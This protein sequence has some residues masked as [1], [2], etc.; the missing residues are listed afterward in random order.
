MV[1][2]SVAPTQPL[3]V[4]VTVNT[5]LVSVAPVFVAV[6][7]IIDDPLPLAPIPIAVLSLFHV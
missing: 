3:A 1:N 6:N 5:P 7:D 4:G 2:V